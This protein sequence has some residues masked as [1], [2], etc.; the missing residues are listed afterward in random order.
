MKIPKKIDPDCLKNSIV[1]VLF[2]PSVPDE[3]LLGEFNNCLSAQLKFVAG[4]APKFDPKTGTLQLG[5]GFFLDSKELVKIE[6][7]GTG[8]V[9]N[10]YKDYPGWATY[11]PVVANTLTKAFDAG[12]VENVNRIG[13]RYI[14]QFENVDLLNNFNVTLDVAIP[15]VNA[16]QL[17]QVKTEVHD[18]NFKI[19]LNLIN[20]MSSDDYGGKPTSVIDVDVIQIVEQVNAAEE[21]LNLVQNGHQRQKEAFFSLLQPEFLKTLNPEY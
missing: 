12:L 4:T 2:K 11:Y 18:G 1:Q 6:V 3:L 10:L 7:S 13:I 17:T 8:L 16:S 19:I 20:K 5:T 14:S 9:F 21:V 15:N